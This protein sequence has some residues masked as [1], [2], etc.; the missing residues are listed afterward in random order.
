MRLMMYQNL[1]ERLLKF[2]SIMF[3]KNNAIHNYN[4]RRANSIH[5]SVGM[6]EHIYKCFSEHL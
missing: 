6:Q 5:T 4:T 3:Q 2:I 1:I